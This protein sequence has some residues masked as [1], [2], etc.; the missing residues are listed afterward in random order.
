MAFQG[1]GYLVSLCE[2]VHEIL[3][4]MTC[5]FEFGLSA[6]SAQKAIGKQKWHSRQLQEVYTYFLDLAMP[7]QPMAYTGIQ[8]H[9]LRLAA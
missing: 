2:A 8:A 9:Q 4:S 3:Y 6:Q 5:R 1:Y 7:L